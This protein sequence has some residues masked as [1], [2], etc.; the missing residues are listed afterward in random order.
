MGVPPVCHYVRNVPCGY[1]V[2]REIYLSLFIVDTENKTH[3]RGH[4]G[5]I[6]EIPTQA[7]ASQPKPYPRTTRHELGSCQPY[8][9]G[10][11]RLRSA[12]SIPSKTMSWI[13][14]LSLKATWRNAS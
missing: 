14:H 4:C 3:A 8:R 12:N 5:H 9:Q 7:R 10:A 2:Q 6:I 11:F 1:V 13:L